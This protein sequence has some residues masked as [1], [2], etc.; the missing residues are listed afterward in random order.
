M[1]KNYLAT[2]SKNNI[3][4]NDFTKKHKQYMKIKSQELLPF[5][6]K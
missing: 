6:G 5:N 3:I 4:E 2:E 1:L